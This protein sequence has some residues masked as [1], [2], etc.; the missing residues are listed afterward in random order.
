[1]WA[2]RWEVQTAQGFEAAVKDGRDTR[3]WETLRLK[4]LVLLGP[5]LISGAW[6]L[7]VLMSFTHGT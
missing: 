4:L 7:G 5:L 1:M 3:Y 6:N 2:A